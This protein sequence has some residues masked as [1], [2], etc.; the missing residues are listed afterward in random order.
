MRPAEPCS[1]SVVATHQLLTNLLQYLAVVILSEDRLRR[2]TQA[3]I[4][5]YDV[6]IL[7]KCNQMN[8]QA[9][10]DIV[11]ADRF[12]Q[13]MDY[14]EDR[15]ELA[16]RKAGDLWANHILENAKA[17]IMTF[18]YIFTTVVCGYPFFIGISV[19]AGLDPSSRFAYLSKWL[20]FGQSL[21][22]FPITDAPVL[23]P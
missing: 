23:V 13:S 19:A 15:A 16:L 12:Q 10:E 18:V 4:T 7:E 21:A 3:V 1:I 8:I 2:I 17:Y 9:L 14:E 6:Q 20:I 22:V 5:E 11:G